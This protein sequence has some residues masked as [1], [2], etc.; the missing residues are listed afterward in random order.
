MSDFL[1][2]VRAFLFS[3]GLNV[4]F[5]VAA[6]LEAPLF[7]LLLSAC[8]SF[9]CQQGQTG[10][11]GRKHLGYTEYKTEPLGQSGHMFGPLPSPAV[12]V[13]SPLPEKSPVTHSVLFQ[14]MLRFP[15]RVT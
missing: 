15:V 12:G 13:W 14:L 4:A 8:K 2:L 1:T 9:R 3:V 5:I 7:P 6:C 10:L 11:M